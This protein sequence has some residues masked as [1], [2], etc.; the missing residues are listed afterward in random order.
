MIRLFSYRIQVGNFPHISFYSASAPVYMTRDAAEVAAFDYLLRLGYGQHKISKKWIHT[1][2][3]RVPRKL[4]TS[5]HTHADRVA[6]TMHGG[7]ARQAPSRQPRGNMA[8]MYRQC[9]KHQG[10][11]AIFSGY[12][13]EIGEYHRVWDDKALRVVGGAV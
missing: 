10:E 9:G 5:R 11:F 3:H 8:L 12:F 1:N 13:D 7:T 2:Q 4:R 6:G